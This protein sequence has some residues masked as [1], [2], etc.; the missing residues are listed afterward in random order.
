MYNKLLFLCRVMFNTARKALGTRQFCSLLY[1]C[2]HI[3]LFYRLSLGY[4][5]AQWW[6]RRCD[7]HNLPWTHTSWA[8]FSDDKTSRHHYS[9]HRLVNFF[10]EHF[11][12]LKKRQQHAIARLASFPGSILQLVSCRIRNFYVEKKI[13]FS[14]QTFIPCLI[15]GTYILG[16]SVK[17]LHYYVHFFNARNS[18]SYQG[19]YGEARSHSDRFW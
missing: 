19:W 8:A 5:V 6:D 14:T 12:C 2:I 16:P 10:I 3:I 1:P 7:D 11:Y 4:S 17:L 13:L 9:R 15:F 18:W